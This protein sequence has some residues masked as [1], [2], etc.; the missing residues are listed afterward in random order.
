VLF[1]W[2]FR[3]TFLR[4]KRSIITLQNILRIFIA[5]REVRLL[6]HITS[7]FKLQSWSRMLPRRNSFQKKR[8]AAVILGAW[9]KMTLTR[10]KYSEDRISLMEN[11]K[12][13]GQ[14]ECLKV[15]LQEESEA[16][17]TAEMVSA[18]FLNNITL[19][20][21]LT[22]SMSFLFFC[23]LLT[24]AFINSPTACCRDARER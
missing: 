3:S 15:R 20:L 9:V 10:R 6:R 11:R 12:M 23:Y 19:T 4:F 22:I 5:V 7:L 2:R 18:S 16:R 21:T 14:L 8:G 17:Q 1:C 24:T 13:S